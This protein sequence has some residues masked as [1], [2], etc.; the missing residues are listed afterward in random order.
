M[1]KNKLVV[2]PQWKEMEV[3]RRGFVSYCLY[4]S[5]LVC[6]QCKGILLPSSL[7]MSLGEDNNNIASNI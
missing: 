6:D 4:L 7:A 2:G 5:M 3:I 1:K